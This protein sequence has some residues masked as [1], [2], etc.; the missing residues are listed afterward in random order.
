MILVRHDGVCQAGC[1][2]YIC[3]SSAVQHIHFDVYVFVYDKSRRE[4][5]DHRDRRRCIER[6]RSRY[7]VDLQK[8]SV[9]DTVDRAFGAGKCNRS[10]MGTRVREFEN[11]LDWITHITVGRDYFAYLKAYFDVRHNAA[12]L[13]D[14]N[15]AKTG[16]GNRSA[17]GSIRH[18]TVVAGMY[19][20][21]VAV[22][23]VNRVFDLVVAVVRLTSSCF[24]HHAVAGDLYPHLISDT[25][26]AV[27]GHAGAVVAFVV[28]E[29]HRT[30]TAK[31]PTATKTHDGEN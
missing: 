26:G 12:F 20:N 3:V 18:K 5:F 16:C 17:L 19:T 8:C 28:S 25:A 24:N 27:H 22:L 30:R 6:K 23:E 4:G 21:D 10:L 9:A 14:G 15:K 13:G 31:N 1:W 29:R 7:A 2:L 11:D